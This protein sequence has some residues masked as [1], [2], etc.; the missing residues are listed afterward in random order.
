MKYK[1]NKIDFQ[2]WK[3]KVIDTVT[4]TNNEQNKD[5]CIAVKLDDTGENED[6]DK[7]PVIIHF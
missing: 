6:G 3:R 5:F 4:Q 7:G 1:Y 2:L